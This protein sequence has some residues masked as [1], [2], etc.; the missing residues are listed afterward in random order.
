MTRT[1]RK[2]ASKWY[3][4]KLAALIYVVDPSWPTAWFCP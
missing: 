2:V 4:V 1:I 3:V